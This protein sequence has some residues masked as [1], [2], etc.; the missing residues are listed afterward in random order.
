MEVNETKLANA[1][2]AS[3][4]RPATEDEIR[5]I[6]AEPGYGS[7]IGVRNAIIVVDD[8][9]ASSPNLVAGAN[10][11]GYHLLNVNLGRD[12][13]ADIVTDIAAACEGDGCPQCGLPLRGSRGVEV[14]NIFKLGT[15][16][17]AMMGAT[18]LDENGEAKPI[19]MG[20]YGI[21]LG[22]LLAC[23]AE[24]HHDDKGLIWPVTI[25]PYHVSLVWIPSDSA[26][27]LATAERIYQT[28]REGGIEVLFDDR[29]ATPGVKFNDADLIG[30]PLRITVGDR[31]LAHGGVELKRRDQAEKRI[32][33]ESDLL[34]AVRAELQNLHDD[35]TRR[36]APVEFPEN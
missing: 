33:P 32:V 17:S 4:L 26:E 7:P 6:G 36:V 13:T 29:K 27:T 2:K 1:V 30:L 34:V 14:G 11:P 10:E 15:R 35:I 20:S 5:A 22:R 24:E 16:Y 31:S 23:V 12:Y 28:L 19:V 21:G 8:A 18:Y 9:V 25:A 3:L